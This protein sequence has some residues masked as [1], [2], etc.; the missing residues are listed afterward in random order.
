[1]GCMDEPGLGIRDW[2]LE[3]AREST[4]Q[5]REAEASLFSFLVFESD[6]GGQ[7][8]RC[9]QS[10]IPNPESRPYKSTPKPTP[11]ELSEPENAAPMLIDT[12]SL[13]RRP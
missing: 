6:R 11:P 1:M 8:W 7:R 3:K 13:M 9:D 12:F 10:R 5:K 2:G 4:Q